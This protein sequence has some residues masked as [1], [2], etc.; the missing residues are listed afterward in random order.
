MRQTETLRRDRDEREKV[1]MPA[2]ET[3]GRRRER[4]IER[5]VWTKGRYKDRERGGD[6][7]EIQR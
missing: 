6:K 7:G 4:M 5:E 3:C 1:E 2:K